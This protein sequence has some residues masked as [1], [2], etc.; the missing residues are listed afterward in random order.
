MGQDARL[1]IPLGI[2]EARALIDIFVESGRCF[3]RRR[4]LAICAPRKL[5]FRARNQFQIKGETMADEGKGTSNKGLNFMGWVIGC[6][7]L[8]VLGGIGACVLMVGGATAI[9][10]GGAITALEAMEGYDAA[11]KQTAREF[12]EQGFDIKPDGSD[13]WMLDQ[14]SRDAFD[15]RVAEILKVKT[16]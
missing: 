12:R 4:C 8:T 5:G 1:I 7:A 11:V 6:L 13:R 9:G 10:V 14:E 16:E 3:E 2:V 15:A